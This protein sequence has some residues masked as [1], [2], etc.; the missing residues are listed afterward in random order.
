MNQYST[1]VTPKSIRREAKALDKVFER[2][3]SFADEDDLKE[4]KIGTDRVRSPSSSSLSVS[5]EEYLDVN[6]GNLKLISPDVP[7]DKAVDGWSRIPAELF[8]VRGSNYL[9][10][11]VKIDSAESCCTCIG[12]DLFKSK[13]E[14]D[15]I[16]NYKGESGVSLHF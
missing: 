9:K 5:S 16:T 4:Y 13:G 14:I 3:A 12:V 15:F 2:H 11:K 10:D 6:I 7:L 8:K 1:K